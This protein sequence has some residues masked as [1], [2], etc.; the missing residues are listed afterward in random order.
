MAASHQAVAQA[1]EWWPRNFGLG[2]RAGNDLAK[3]AWPSA[4][5]LMRWD[6]PAGWLST[7]W[8]QGRA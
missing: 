7:A 6:T 3:A 8:W 2:G 4:N 5:R 1:N